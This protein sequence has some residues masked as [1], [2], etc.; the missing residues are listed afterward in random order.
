MNMDKD[1][2]L[3]GTRL[4]EEVFNV[5]EKDINAMVITNR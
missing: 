5:A 2:E 3:V 1:N 4:E